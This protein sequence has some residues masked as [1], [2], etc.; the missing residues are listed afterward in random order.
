MEEL[1]TLICYQKRKKIPCTW[2]SRLPLK[3]CHWLPVGRESEQFQT[4][5]MGDKGGNTTGTGLS[6]YPHFLPCDFDTK[7]TSD[8]V[9]KLIF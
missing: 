3:G 4:R 1:Y 5:G 6:S 2:M 7:Y 9:R 8:L